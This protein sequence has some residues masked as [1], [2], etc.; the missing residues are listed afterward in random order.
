MRVGDFGELLRP[1]TSRV[2]TLAGGGTVTAPIGTIFS[3][4]GVPIPG[5]DL[6]NCPTCG[7]FSPFARNYLNAFPLP[8]LPGIGRNFTVNRAEHANCR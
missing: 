4:A 6:R 1:G 3:P 2:Y 5:N 8:D 7:G